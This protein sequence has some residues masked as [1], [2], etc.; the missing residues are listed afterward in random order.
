M[1]S[2][3]REGALRPS[4]HPAG[5]AEPAGGR[6]G[7]GVCCA[8]PP[9][10]RLFG[11]SHVG[12]AVQ[13]HFHKS[14]PTIYNVTICIGCVYRC[15][16][17]EAIWWSEVLEDYQRVDRRLT[18]TLLRRGCGL[19]LFALGGVVVSA[20]EVSAY[21][22]TAGWYHN[23]VI[24]DNGVT[25]WGADV[26]GQSTV[27]AGL[28][29]P[30]ALAAG[31]EHTCAI[32]DSGVTCWG[33]GRYGQSTVPAGLVN[34][35]ALAAG[36]NYNCAIDDNGVNCWGCDVYDQL[37]VPTGLIDPTILAAEA[38]HTCAIDD[39]GVAC[40]GSNFFGESAVPEDLVFIGT[41]E[42]EI[43]I[44]PGSELNRINLLSRGVTSV[45]VLGSENFDVGDVDVTTLAFGPDHAP[46]ARAR[47]VGRHGKDVNADGFPDLIAR[48]RTDESG[49][50]FG[51]TEACLSGETLD[52]T[53]FRGCDTIQTVPDR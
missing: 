24:D 22:L 3:Q 17:R 32:D 52:G 7:W 26:S 28:I 48:F 20:S 16:L 29:N 8:V 36:A 44:K 41:Q 42:V 39:D 34:P 51:D 49:I 21:D 19:F 46:A 2:G 37:T 12:T 47:T 27:P 33:N 50:A 1:I 25:C 31:R 9:S 15:F 5:G 18:L 40:W 45:A 30:T 14:N 11:L 4:L 6:A 53:P 43:D 10:H 35:T 38:N 13:Q 23:C